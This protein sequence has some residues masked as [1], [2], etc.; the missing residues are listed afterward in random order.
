MK[1]LLRVDKQLQW[2]QPTTASTASAA[3]H[4]TIVQSS[5]FISA[6]Q[7]FCARF[8]THSVTP[9][10]WSIHQFAFD[11]VCSNGVAHINCARSHS[12]TPSHSFTPLRYSITLTLTLLSTFTAAAVFFWCSAVNCTVVWM[13]V[14]IVVRAALPLLAET[15]PDKKDWDWDWSLFPAL[16]LGCCKNETL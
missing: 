3:V 13:V 5:S 6:N 1:L 2:R 12:L 16:L 8:S 10:I 4:C 11:F 7:S 9:I 15:L 14:W